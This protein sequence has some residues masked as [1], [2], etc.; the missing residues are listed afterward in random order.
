MFCRIMC[1]VLFDLL[2]VPAPSGGFCPA[3]ALSPRDNARAT[4][5]MEADACAVSLLLA[6]L[7]RAD[8][9]ATA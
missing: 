9:G 7:R 2:A 1:A 3:N 8:G 5:A 6:W 4:Y